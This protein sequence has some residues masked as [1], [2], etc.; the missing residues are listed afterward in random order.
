M[1]L[2][3]FREDLRYPFARI[4]HDDTVEVHELEAQG[5]GQQSAQGAL[6]ATHVPDDGYRTFQTSASLPRAL[7]AFCV[8]V[9]GGANVGHVVHT[10][11]LEE[12]FCE[13]DR[14]H[15]LPYDRCSRYRTGVGALLES[16]GGFSCD[17]VDRT[18]GFGDGGDGLH[19]RSDHNRPPVRHP[20]FESPEAVAVAGETSVLREYL[21]L[22]FAGPPGREL[23]AHPELDAFDRIDR[24]H[25]CGEPGIQFVAPIDIGAEACRATPG[26]DDELPPEGV[27]GVA[28]GVDLRLHPLRD[29]R[30]GTA[31]LGLIRGGGVE[32][33]LFL[34]ISDGT[35]PV[36]RA[37]YLDPEL[38]Q[39]LL[40]HATCCHAGRSLA[41][42]GTFE[43]ISQVVEVVL[44]HPG[45]VG[46]T[47]PGQCDL[48]RWI[49]DRF[50]AHAMFPVGVVSVADEHSY[51]RAQS[52]TVAHTAKKLDLVFL[53]L[54]APTPPVTFLPAGKVPVHIP[55]DEP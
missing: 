38:G 21:V 25:G 54:L 18:E 2:A 42:A 8:G 53:Y 41:G 39:K 13:H 36:D 44:L 26:D 28:G 31:H 48:L 14:S 4:L 23:E 3:V 16:P 9:V 15:G 46:V 50:W 32:C 49:L 51:G 33:G 20:T 19:R 47:G 5:T 10:E 40:C 12:R 34:G 45:K 55:G 30:V 6:T 35:D 22:Y 29:I 52:V 27:A 24:H 37:F 1:F 11:L 43:D 7:H 17:Q